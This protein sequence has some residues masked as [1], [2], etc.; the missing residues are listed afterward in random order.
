MLGERGALV[1]HGLDP[2][3]PAMLAGNIEA[4]AED[5]ANR[6]R[7]RT[8]LDGLASEIVVDSLRGDWTDYYRNIAGALA[9]QVDLAVKPE[10]V[11]RAMAVFDA[12]MASA[13]TGETIRLGV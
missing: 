9:G 4:A 5:P 13:Q 7:L 11:R 1:K 12:A 2:Q 6:A 10:E 8:D 3:E